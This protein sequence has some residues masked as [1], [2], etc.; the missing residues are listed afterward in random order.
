MEKPSDG[1]LGFI[2]FARVLTYLVYAYA[3][4]ATVFLLFGFFLL[5]FGANQNTPFVNFVYNISAHFLK[6]FRGI[7]PGQTVSDTGYFDSAALF[8]IIFYGIFAMAIHSLIQYIT[9]KMVKHQR[10]L[11]EIQNYNRAK[12][13]RKVSISQRPPQ[14]TRVNS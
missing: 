5:L 7:F 2:K 8:A 14:K 4:I 10:E 12:A 1:K 13:Q 3:I 6:P 11:I 9:L